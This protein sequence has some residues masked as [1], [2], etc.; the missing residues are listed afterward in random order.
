MRFVPS[1]SN[2]ERDITTLQNERGDKVDHTA[3]VLH[4]AELPVSAVTTTTNGPDDEGAPRHRRPEHDRVESN[5]C[6][7]TKLS[8]TSE[9]V[10]EAEGGETCARRER[11]VINVGQI[12]WECEGGEGLASLLYHLF[13]STS[14]E[15]DNSTCLS[16]ERTSS[17]D[18]IAKFLHRT[19]PLQGHK[20]TC[21]T[22]RFSWDATAVVLEGRTSCSRSHSSSLNPDH[23][24]IFVYGDDQCTCVASLD[25]CPFSLGIFPET[26]GK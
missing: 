23:L 7:E 17:H 12:V 14:Q 13:P 19:D 10:G 15:V 16:T 20:Q 18:E 24:P 5:A 22:P 25:A 26:M 6:P 11:L 4:G 2:V 3:D 9:L 8:N 1:G 21:G